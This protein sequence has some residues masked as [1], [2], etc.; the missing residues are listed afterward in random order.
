[1][2]NLETSVDNYELIQLLVLMLVKGQ[3]STN[4]SCCHSTAAA[5]HFYKFL[6]KYFV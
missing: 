1:M 6:K 3:Q 2:L 4:Q 5:A